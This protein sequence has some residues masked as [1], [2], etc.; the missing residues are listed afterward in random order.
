MG[1]L[2]MYRSRNVGSRFVDFLPG[3]V[4]SA[5]P[6]FSIVGRL[7]Y[8][9]NRHSF[10]GWQPAASGVTPY[11][12]M[13]GYY[14]FEC[15]DYTYI[16][17]GTCYWGPSGQRP[18]AAATPI[19]GFVEG[20]TAVTAQQSYTW[21]SFVTGG[22]APYRAEWYRKYSSASTP[23]LVATTT[24]IHSATNS[25]AGSWTGLVDKCEAFTITL[26]AWSSDGQMVT[27]DHAVPSVTCPPPPLSASI[28]GPAIVTVKSTYTYSLLLSG[29]TGP[30]YSWSERY[31]TD[32]AGTSCTAWKTLIGYGLTVGRVLGPDCSGI[33][34]ANYRLKAVV[35]NNDGRQVT[36]QKVTAL[37][38]GLN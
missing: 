11:A 7:E 28:S 30:S 9:Y 13:L 16:F 26:K 15:Y 33:R 17:L 5:N 1:R 32:A 24:G 23:T 12:D 21:T 18:A 6:Q 4:L 10:G 36:A 37:C 19:Q 34:E 2:R 22:V 14:A 3:G 27:D 38:Q 8:F 20:K 31:C 35:N 29:F 25:T